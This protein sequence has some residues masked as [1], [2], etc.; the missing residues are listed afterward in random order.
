MLL[1]SSFPCMNPSFLASVATVLTCDQTILCFS[2]PFVIAL[3]T[4]MINPY[5]CMNILFFASF[6]SVTYVVYDQPHIRMWMPSSLLIW[7]LSTPLNSSV[8]FLL[9]VRYVC[10][11]A[12]ISMPVVIFLVIP[13]HADYIFKSLFLN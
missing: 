1:Y 7:P 13:F 11:Y 2:F 5:P 10:C 8:D 12:M 4:F 9:S 3:Y 6:T